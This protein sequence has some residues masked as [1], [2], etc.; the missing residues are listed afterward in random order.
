M[1]ATAMVKPVTRTFQFISAAV[2]FLFSGKNGKTNATARKHNAIVLIANPARPKLN[3]DG[4]S[5]S[6][7]TR[8]LK[9]HDIAKIY[10][11]TVPTCPIDII[12]L[13]AMDEPM[14]MRLSNVVMVNVAM[15]AFSGMSQPAGT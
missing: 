4:R 9:M 11:P 2:G 13:K 14:I 8:F 3:R 1:T 7:T 5:G 15:T 6:P 12:T 10:E